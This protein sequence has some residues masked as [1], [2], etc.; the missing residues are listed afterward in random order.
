MQRTVQPGPDPLDVSSVIDLER[1]WGSGS[2]F[3]DPILQYG[4][5]KYEKD[6]SN[7]VRMIYPGRLHLPF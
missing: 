3:H 6:G 4:H 1:R 5:F 7:R 2:S